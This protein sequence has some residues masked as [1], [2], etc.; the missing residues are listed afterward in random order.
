M[1]K[2]LR[3]EYK[4]L[5][6]FKKEFSKRVGKRNVDGMFKTIANKALENTL[7]EA[8]KLTPVL[9][10]ELKTSWRKNVKSAR[11]SKGDIVATAV[12]KAYNEEAKAAHMDPY[13]AEYVEEGHK[14]VPWR[15]RTHGV[16]MLAKAEIDTERK[17]QGIVNDEIKKLFGG[18]FD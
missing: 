11:K 13:Y 5:K 4:E 2:V 18:L 17:L 12:N 6:D 8:E 15:K 3:F 9:T 7:S 1:G 16:H 14:K 10:G